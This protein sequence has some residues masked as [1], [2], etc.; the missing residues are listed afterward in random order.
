LDPINTK[1]LFLLGHVPVPYSGNLNPDGHPDHQGA[2]PADVYYGDVNGIW[3]DASVSSPTNAGAAART[4]NVP[5]DGKFDQSVL[6]SAME[7]QVG[8]VDLWGMTSFALSETQLL[9]NYLDK[10]HNYRKKLT[11]V[12]NAGVI[13]DNFGY[14]NAEAFA[15][16]GFKTF[17]P[18]VNAGNVLSA[19]Y[20][21]S[22]TGGNGYQ[23]SYGC[24]GG[25]YTS[26]GGIGQT[27][28]FASS[29]LQG[30]FTMLFGSYFGDWDVPNNFLRAP[31]CQG[32]TLTSVWAGRPHW[33]LHHMGMGENIGYSA[34]VTQNNS[35]TYFY[36]YGN[37]YIYILIY[38]LN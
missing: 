8:R 14:F 29:N 6:P 5:G 25:S 13:D 35:N 23:W 3:T 16:N 30:T 32:R 31:L 26:A 19:D 34:W 28:N 20:F 4:Q 33:A 11:T 7:L 22:M 21:T 24:G 1:A 17:S 18:L 10:D 36:N 12:A 9:K 27:T 2:W 37:I 38:Y 15:A